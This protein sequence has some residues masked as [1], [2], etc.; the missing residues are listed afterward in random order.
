MKLLYVV[1]NTHQP[2]FYVSNKEEL[3]NELKK[4]F[5]Y[6]DSDVMNIEYIDYANIC[7]VSMNGHAVGQLIGKFPTESELNTEIVPDNY[8]RKLFIASELNKDR[9]RHAEWLENIRSI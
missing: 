2:D 8:E 1:Y 4:R 5:D 9:K 7:Q 3:F 6:N